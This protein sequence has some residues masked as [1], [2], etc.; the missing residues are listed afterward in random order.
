M[1]NPSSILITLLVLLS[2]LLAS[3]QGQ[4][5]TNPTSLSGYT[6]TMG[7][8]S[9]E[10]RVLVSG[11]GLSGNLTA[12]APAGF[13][14]SWTSGSGFG[15]SIT[16]TQGGT[17]TTVPLFARLTGAA[18]GPVSGSI[19]LASAGAPTLSVP[20][21]GTV[22]AA[23]TPNP[24]PI[25]SRL[26]SSSGQGGYPAWITVYGF[27][28]VPG[29]TLSLQADPGLVIPTTF[30]SSNQLEALVTLPS[31][32]APRL[33]YFLVTNPGPGGGT[34]GTQGFFTIN[35]GP[36]MLT[37]FSPTSGPVGTRVTLTG[38]NMYLFGSSTGTTTSFN[39]A[40]TQVIGPPSPTTEQY[41][42]EVP[43]GA[44][45]GLITVTNAN[46]ATVSATP[47]TVT[48]AP[49]AFFESFEQGT[50]TSYAAGLVVLQSGG[51]TM[52][53][54]LLGTTAG[55]D[56]FNGSKSAR[57]RGGGFLEM[58][59]DKPLG[60]GIITISAATYG[61]ETGVSFIPELSADGG[62]TYSSLLGSSSP[63][64]LTG[65]LT[66]YSF[67]ANRPGNVRLRIRST[68]TAA[69]T[70]PRLNID[71]I[72]I[73]DYTIVSTRPGRRLP[74]LQ[75]YPV[76]AHDQLTL[77]GAGPVRVTLFDLLGRVALPARLLA[78]GEAL[79][80][81]ATLPAGSYLLHVQAPSGQRVVHVT[82]E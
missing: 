20:L 68:N 23:P 10:Q 46:G 31:V 24:M 45:T 63:P 9:A 16:L 80:L 17:V 43:A 77:Q 30:M 3:G 56:K 11:T 61:T 62:I 28:F 12:S 47:F 44:T 49:P 65:T 59:T 75:V 37:S 51:W 4:L 5:T 21:S 79:H 40:A 60:A 66:Q 70:P 33:T 14:I 34:A 38:R 26:G 22:T 29:A 19:A 55:A 39:G 50:K 41:I 73:Q 35:P 15:N 72:G 18:L 74:E 6:T 36:P 52:S 81:P 58:D 8:P 13:E 32:A 67:I 42:T 48:T 64:V 71:D 69:A 53:E 82:K 57:L 7:T 27:D 78:D 2:S 54:A 1:K 25:L 76:P